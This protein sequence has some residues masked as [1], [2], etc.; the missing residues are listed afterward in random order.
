[1]H[2]YF[3]SHHR[4]SDK[5]F[6]DWD[7]VIAALPAEYADL[8]KKRRR[9]TTES[10][11]TALEKYAVDNK[12]RE[13]TPSSIQNNLPDV[14]SYFQLHRR[15][16]DGKH[17][18]WKSIV[19]EMPES[20]SKLW[21]KSKRYHEYVPE[22]QYRNEQE[23]ST[24]LDPHRSK[25]YTLIEAKSEEERQARDVIAHELIILAKKGNDSAKE[26]LVD[27]A[28]FIVQDWFER[29]PDTFKGLAEQSDRV[30]DRVERCIYYYETGTQPFFGYL[31][32][33]LKAEA[34]GYK[35]SVV[36]FNESALGRD[37]QTHGTY[38]YG[39]RNGDG[40]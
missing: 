20:L 8:W 38:Y 6:V 34:L 9:H 17:I 2:N 28:Q 27:Y 21:T 22:V 14:H 26:K 39:K 25:L 3:K 31:Y 33:T 35:H 1:M 24:L 16:P 7:S 18:D 13:I 40:K 29:F 4:T 10:A 30:R 5:K 11:I 36:E 19:A 37:D 15:T 32:L 23:V 12:P